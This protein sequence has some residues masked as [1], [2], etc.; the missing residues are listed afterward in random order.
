MTELHSE[1]PTGNVV[2]VTDPNG[3]KKV[4]LEQTNVRSSTLLACVASVGILLSSGFAAYYN[5]V[6]RIDSATYKRWN[7]DAVVAADQVRKE[8]DPDYP[9]IN[10]QQVKEIAELTALP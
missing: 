9:A 7:Q 6:G 5:M 4:F 8:I 2:A 3:K 10:I 1:K